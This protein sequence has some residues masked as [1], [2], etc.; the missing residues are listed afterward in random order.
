MIYLIGSLRNPEIP[1]IAN[2]IREAGHEVFDDWFAAG[3]EADDKWRD[4][5]QA[6]GHDY[7]TALGGYAARHVFEF[8]RHHLARAESVVL[9]LPAGKSG[10]LELGW[11]LGQGKRG[12]VLLDKDP[13]RWD[14]MLQFATAV[15]SSIEQLLFELD[16]PYTGPVSQ[17]T[18][19]SVFKD[20][21]NDDIPF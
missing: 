10:H 13:E 11:A 17:A 12:F 14:V 7:I 19:D 21:Y 6:R 4:Y 16:G 8:D 15:C 20:V 18:F 3:P 9:A 1:I 5:E 2:R